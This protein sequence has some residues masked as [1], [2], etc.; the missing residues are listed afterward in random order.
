MPIGIIPAITHTASIEMVLYALTTRM[1]MSRNVLLNFLWFCFVFSASIQA[2]PPYLSID[3]ETLARRRLLLLLGPELFGMILAIALMT[4]V[5]FSQAYSMWLLKFSRSSII[6][7]RYLSMR[8]EAMVCSPTVI[9]ARCT[10]LQLLT[11]I[12]SVLWWAICS[13][14]PCIQL[15]I[16]SIASAANISTSSSVSPVTPPGVIEVKERQTAAFLKD[17]IMMVI[18]SYGLTVDQIFSVTCDNGANMLAAVRQL[19]QEF[20]ANF[21]TVYDAT[22]DPNG[23]NITTEEEDGKQQE[24][25]TAALSDQ[26]Q[27]HL[28][29][30]RCA[31]HTLQLAILDVVN[32]SNEEVQ[33]LTKVAKKCRSVKYTTFFELHGATYPP[34]WGQTR[35]GGIYVMILKF[36]EQR[37][38]FDQLAEQFQELDLSDSWE[39]AEKYEQA[40]KP[41]YVLTKDM[42]AEHVSLSDFYLQWIIAT[43]KVKQTE[44]NPFAGVLV[45]SMNN[46]LRNLQNSRA[47]KM[48]LYLDPRLNY[49]GSKLFSNEEK[50]EIQAYIVET[51]N[52]IHDIRSLKSKTSCDPP[53][54]I[55]LEDEND[56]FITQLFG[57][58]TVT[59]VAGEETGFMQQLKAVEVEPRR[60]F[61]FDLSWRFW[62]DRKGTHPELSAVV[63]VVLATP[64]NQVS[65]ERAVSALALI[66]TN[67]RST[68]GEDTLQNLLLVKLN[69]E[70]FDK[71]LPTPDQP[72]R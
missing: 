43:Q 13:F 8:F 22:D 70:V 39:F 60:S 16:V 32:K 21:L 72:F 5:A 27:E 63:S 6:T 40:F 18:Q 31:V 36:L 41:L 23:V 47:F 50:E 62:M 12:T 45:V 19:K 64:S 54:S 33:K 24:L 44:P 38:F 69:K 28:N 30:V 53:S 3:E 49:A 66:L 11:N 56:I 10:A 71:I 4:F 1:A 46:R 58:S 42:Q 25:L 7:P 52:R 14:A 2:G 34:V 17:Q 67:T 35:W 65:V 51:W 55:S 15:P 9:S 57:S 68:L 59:I 37:P 48:A 61:N 26:L 29:L 20:E